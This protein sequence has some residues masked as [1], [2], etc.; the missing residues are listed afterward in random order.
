MCGVC[1]RRTWAV[2]I[3]SSPLPLPVTFVIIT[4]ALPRVVLVTVVVVVDGLCHRRHH[5][6]HTLPSSSSSSSSESSLLLRSIK[7]TLR[8]RASVHKS[9][10]NRNL[11]EF[12]Q[13][14]AYSSS[15][16]QL[17]KW[18]SRDSFFLFFSLKT[19]AWN[20]TQ[21][22]SL[23]AEHKKQKKKKRISSIFSHFFFLL[24]LPPFPLHS[25]VRCAKWLPIKFYALRART[26]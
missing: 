4:I 20:G 25:F 14:M 6:H 13:T 5:H 15:V 10:V 2:G 24:F 17:V 7:S 8:F 11:N 12:R 26:E 9:E 3:P 1:V 21:C 18:I 22:C 19:F 23:L 16:C